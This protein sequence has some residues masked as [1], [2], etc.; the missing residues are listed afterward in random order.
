MSGIINTE[1]T[2]WLFKQLLG[3]DAVDSNVVQD[4]L[5]LKKTRRLRT[6]LSEKE[7]NRINTY[8]LERS[9]YFWR[10]VTIFFSSGC[11]ETEMMRLQPD[12]VNIER[13]EYTSWV[14]KGKDYRQVLRPISQNAILLW[15]E[16]IEECEE[17]IT[18]NKK[19]VKRGNVFL[20]SKFLKPGLTPIRADQ[21]GRRRKKYVKDE[22]Q[23]A[24]DFYSLKHLYSDLISEQLGL[25]YAQRQN[26][27][28]ELSITKLYAIN[29]DRRLLE[30]LEG[31]NIYF[32]SSINNL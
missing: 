22:L 26:A 12:D 24:V 20:F 13:K 17:L 15:T 5:I 2:C 3:E 19:H 30:K 23:I 14:L 9:Y 1:P 18:K 10:F 16:I 6:I 21:I 28:D 7:G 31:I 25:Q 11:S 4:I 32:A 8:L 27:H 29:E